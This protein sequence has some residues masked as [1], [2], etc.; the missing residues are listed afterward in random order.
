MATPDVGICPRFNS[1][2]VLRA[3]LMFPE[4]FQVQNCGI[5]AKAKTEVLAQ[6][7]QYAIS[8]KISRSW[9]NV[10]EPIKGA[11]REIVEESIGIGLYSTDQK[12]EPKLKNNVEDGNNGL[13]V[14]QGT[15]RERVWV[16]G[17]PFGVR[18][19]ERSGIAVS[20]YW[21]GLRPRL[22]LS[23][24]DGIDTVP[25]ML[26]KTT[27][28]LLLTYSGVGLSAQRHFGRM[29]EI[30]HQ[31]TWG[32]GALI[33]QDIKRHQAAQGT[34]VVFSEFPSGKMI[35]WVQPSKTTKRIMAVNLVAIAV[36]ATVVRL[37]IRIR[38]RDSG[39]MMFMGSLLLPVAPSLCLSEH[40]WGP[41][42][43]KVAPQWTS[44]ATSSQLPDRKASDSQGYSWKSGVLILDVINHRRINPTPINSK[45]NPSVDRV[46][47]VF[48]IDS[49]LRAQEKLVA[50]LPP[51]K[52]HREK[53]LVCEDG[54][55]LEQIKNGGDRKEVGL[56]VKQYL[57]RNLVGK[58][59]EQRKADL[60]TNVW[61]SS[62]V[63]P[64]LFI[65]IRSLNDLAA[66]ASFLL[67]S[68]PHLLLRLQFLACLLF[69]K[70]PLNNKTTSRETS[71]SPVSL[72]FPQKIWVAYGW[73]KHG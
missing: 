61:S 58:M 70:P 2:E 30:R 54:W 63:R 16:E 41:I 21:F 31:D 60:F 7:F 72:K 26:F 3:N 52:N 28:A 15:T 18:D 27:V 20:C 55:P 64:S 36:L 4:C 9:E 56:E 29:V 59:A 62:I 32:S 66:A 10:D 17:H 68:M 44:L 46:K 33:R 23:L 45:C 40:V 73:H 19:N 50:T 51:W 1:V 42:P 22:L 49:L 47:A 6:E 38:T 43:L 37:R 8:T 65:V 12:K 69:L 71:D 67:P 57:E 35:V 48:R 25:H 11:I 14:E 34:R 53:N 5:H 24:E 13:E 39:K